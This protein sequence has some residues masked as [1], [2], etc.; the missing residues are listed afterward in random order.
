[1][2]HERITKRFISLLEKDEKLKRLVE[3]DLELAKKNN[4]DKR[5]NPAQSL[6]ELYDFLDWSVK[7]M[8]WEILPNK[9]YEALYTSMDQ[10]TGYFWFIFDQPLE[11]L[12][13]KGFYYP[14]LQYLEPIASWIKDYSKTWG[15]FLSKR[16]SWNEK[17][18]QLALEDGKFGLK[19]GWYGDNNI[20]HTFNDFFSRKLIDEKQRPISAANVIAPADSTPMG[21]YKIGEN[22]KLK[23]DVNIKSAN[24]NDIGELI[25]K[26]SQYCEAFKEGTLTHTFLDIYDYHRYHFPVSGKILELRKINGANAGGGITVWDK[27]LEKYVYYNEMGFQMIETRSCVILKTENFGL[28]AV[29]P[30]GM[31]Q[32]CSVNFEKRLKVGDF[33]QK[34]DPMGY[35]QFGGS[36]IVMIF[37]K[38]VEVEDLTLKDGSGKPRH[39]L[40]GQPYANLKVKQ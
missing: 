2:K 6:E 1:M 18:Y 9:K 30:V 25:G 28:V 11:E 39:L 8:P 23:N 22:N 14:T 40:M 15:K 13:G 5:T 7:C 37:Q 38:G 17:Y 35:F 29:L 24:L 27:K 21:F 12:Q 32:I 36:D 34:G 31:S 19:N 20:W 10:M 33:V 4:P 26:E 3:K 16:K